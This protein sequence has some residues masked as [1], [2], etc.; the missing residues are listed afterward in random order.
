[1]MKLS[2]LRNVFIRQQQHTSM[3]YNHTVT[4]YN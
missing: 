4:V 2:Y 3:L 1:M